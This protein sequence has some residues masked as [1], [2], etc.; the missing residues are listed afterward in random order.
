[1]TSW[2]ADVR[3]KSKMSC[4]FPYLHR[5]PFNG[6]GLMIV[7]HGDQHSGSSRR[8]MPRAVRIGAF[9]QLCVVEAHRRTL[10]EL[11]GQLEENPGHYLARLRDAHCWGRRW[12]NR[13]FT[14]VFRD[15]TSPNP[16]GEGGCAV[17]EHPNRKVESP[18]VSTDHFLSN[19]CHSFYPVTKEAA[20]AA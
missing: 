9:R 14:G 2:S 5:S 10:R 6:K 3:S 17:E 13:C 8:S 15:S 19:P 16:V 7:E 1:M 20:S 18:S 11:Q 12:K 4:G